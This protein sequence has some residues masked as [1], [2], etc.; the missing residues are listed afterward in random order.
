[1]S[2]LRD[3]QTVDLLKCDVES[4]E[5]LFLRSYPE[6]LRNV[7]AAVIELHPELCNADECLHLLGEYGLARQTVL[8]TG[9]FGR[10]VLAQR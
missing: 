4:A 8:R 7:R 6:R 9:N 5:L 1:M 10:T 2:H 3:V